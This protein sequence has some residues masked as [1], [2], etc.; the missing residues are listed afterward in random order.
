VRGVLSNLTPP[1][2]AG[3]AALGVTIHRGAVS[4]CLI[5]VAELARGART[6]IGSRRPLA[7]ELLR[8]QI[9]VML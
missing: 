5:D 6:G 9:D 7:D 8:T 3:T 4:G 2:S 1:T